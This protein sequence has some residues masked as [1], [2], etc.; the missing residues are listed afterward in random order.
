M[1]R[2][3]SALEE[4]IVNS[5]KRYRNKHNPAVDLI[6]EVIAHKE[7]NSP[8]Y[9]AYLTTDQYEKVKVLA[10]MPPPLFSDIKIPLFRRLRLREVVEGK[11]LCGGL[12]AVNNPG[13]NAAQMKFPLNNDGILSTYNLGNQPYIEAGVGVYNILNIIRVDLI[14]RFTYFNHPGISTTGIRVSTGLDF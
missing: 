7:E 1:R 10:D 4:V 3:N 2:G 6:R 13:V 12:R 14:R 11:I 5:R 9:C 8:A